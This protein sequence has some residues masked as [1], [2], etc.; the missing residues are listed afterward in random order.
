MDKEDKRK[1]IVK[2]IKRKQKGSFQPAEIKVNEH[3][4]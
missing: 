3:T 1:R 2:A 4:R